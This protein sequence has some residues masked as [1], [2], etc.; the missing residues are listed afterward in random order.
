MRAALRPSYG[1]MLIVIACAT[2]AAGCRDAVV[3]QN[4]DEHDDDDS[5]SWMVYA[6]L[7]GPQLRGPAGG[8]NATC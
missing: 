6:G 4:P 7:I 1:A 8:V 3:D 5:A 2:G